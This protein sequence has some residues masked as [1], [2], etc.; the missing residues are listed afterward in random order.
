MWQR[1]KG[2]L[3]D[4]PLTWLRSQKRH[5]FFSLILAAAFDLQMN[6]L[7]KRLTEL[8]HTVADF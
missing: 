3:Q 5:S 1:D 6:K 7:P 2:D 8:S 4:I